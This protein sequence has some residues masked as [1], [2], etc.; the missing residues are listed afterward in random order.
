MFARYVFHFP[1]LRK[2]WPSVD[3]VEKNAKHHSHI[4]EFINKTV[5]EHQKTFSPESQPR[6]FIDA[7]LGAMAETVDKD[8]SFH[9][10]IGIHHL[11]Q[12]LVDLFFAGSETTSSTLS[13]AVLYL[14]LH[15][16]VQVIAH[17]QFCI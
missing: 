9:E 12:T 5:E 1:F 7:Y 10:D 13:W 11:N 17:F 3:Q 15:P 8:S 4:R 6:D 2:I 14:I 16:D